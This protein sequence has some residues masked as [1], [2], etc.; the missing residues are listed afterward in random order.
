MRPF[1]VR[2]FELPRTPGPGGLPPPPKEVPGF[3][4]DAADIDGALAACRQRLT[5]DGRE[6]RSLS[7]LAGTEADISAIVYAGGS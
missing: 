3:A 6:V 7:C 5:F 1:K 2:L 4:V